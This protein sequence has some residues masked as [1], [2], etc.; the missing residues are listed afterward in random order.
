MF[1]GISLPVLFA[2]KSTKEKRFTTPVIIKELDYQL[3]DLFIFSHLS[4]YKSGQVN[5]G[6]PARL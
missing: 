3:T 4:Q 5:R 2:T 6:L 1:A